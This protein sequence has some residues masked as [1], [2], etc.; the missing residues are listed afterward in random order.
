MG[1]PACWI[2]LLIAEN[3]QNVFVT[4]FETEAIVQKGQ[5]RIACDRKQ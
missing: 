5:K 3:S 2:C 4:D 1:T